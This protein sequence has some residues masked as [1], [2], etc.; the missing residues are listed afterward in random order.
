MAAI[1]AGAPQIV[2]AAG[3]KAEF[4][5]GG[6]GA[7]LIVLHGELGV[8]GWLDSFARLARHYDVI[9][10]SLPGFGQSE[11]P[12]WIMGVH[13]LAAWVTWFARDLGISTPV[14]LV[15]CSLGGWVAAEIAAVAPQFIDRLVLVGAMGLKPDH[16]EIFDYFLES[17][18]TGLRRAFRRPDESAEFM[19][20][21]GR[22]GTQEETD[23]VEQH[24]EMTCRIA[25][26]PYMHSL[27]LRHLLPG[28]AV[29][30]LVVWGREDAITPL[31][32][33]AIYQRAIPG[34]RLVAI[35]NCGHMPEMEEPAR[36]ADLVQSFLA[37]DAPAPRD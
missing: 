29:P 20:F 5:R 25:W 18:P 13:D 19:R 24:R 34:A 4:R 9:V 16:G 2:A 8:P 10:P 35:E 30:T 22:D 21:W 15:G 27:T 1:S 33:G 28:V 37:S 17:G 14:K 6:A 31:E 12:D 7:P 3:I 11:R 36:F 26:K 23:R 32:C